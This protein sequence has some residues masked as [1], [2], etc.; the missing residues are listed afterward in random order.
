MK[1]LELRR[2]LRGL[3]KKLLQIMKMELNQLIQNLLKMRSLQRTKKSTQLSYNS[4]PLLDYLKRK[5]N[6]KNF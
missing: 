2:R 5:L 1:Q 3:L 6:L 4:Q